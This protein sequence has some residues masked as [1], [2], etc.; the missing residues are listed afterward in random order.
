[1]NPRRIVAI[2]E[3]LWDL[4]P[5]GKKLGGAP[6]NVAHHARSLGADVVLVSRVGRDPLGDEA[7]RRLESEGLSVAEVQR[8]EG[9][10]TGT[11]AVQIDRDG[12]PRFELAADVAWDRIESPRDVRAD[13]VC[14]GTLAQRGPVT[15]RA[16]RRLLR[17]GALR[18]LD[19]NLRDPYW[20]EEVILSSLALAD[21]VKLS[22]AELDRCG[23]PAGDARDRI[24]RLARRFHLSHVA[25]TRGSRGSLLYSRGEWVE[26]SG[27][28]V[29]VEDAV[30]AGDAFT[31][32]L[33][34]GVLKGD[35]LDRINGT[36]NEVAAYVC[37]QPGATPQLPVEL[38]G[39]VLEEQP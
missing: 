15:R 25:L 10:P 16:I 33:V 36:A 18:V 23:L 34:V 17:P 6:G 29:D 24:A 30:G 13:A 31:A 35:P 39:K 5:G 14:F 1:M 22:E 19:L 4:L 32:A 37:T 11:A 2:G 20:S 8:D 38:R 3:L 7:L 21:V 27:L 26:H 9:A 12:Q 28:E